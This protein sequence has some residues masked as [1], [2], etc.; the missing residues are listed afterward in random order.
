MLIITR[1][2]Q[3]DQEGEFGIRNVKTGGGRLGEGRE[4]E[5]KEWKKEQTDQKGDSQR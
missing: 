3:T 5:G 2:D 4:M 1:W